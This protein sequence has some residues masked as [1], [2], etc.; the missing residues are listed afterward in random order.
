M[1]IYV[2]T[3]NFSLWNMISEQSFLPPGTPGKR[4]C[5]LEIAHDG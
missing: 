4:V 2:Q 5:S 3:W 1:T